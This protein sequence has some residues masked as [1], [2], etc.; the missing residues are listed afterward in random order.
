MTKSFQSVQPPHANASP[1]LQN[2]FPPFP[3]VRGVS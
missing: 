2:V 1:D 3:P